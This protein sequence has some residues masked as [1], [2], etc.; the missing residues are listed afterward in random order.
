MARQGPAVHSLSRNLAQRSALGGRDR[1]HRKTGMRRKHSFGTANVTNRM[2]ARET[3]PE[4]EL[5]HGG[6]MSDKALVPVQCDVTLERLV[7]GAILARHKQADEALTALAAE[8]FFR[9]KDASLSDHQRIFSAAKTLKERGES[10]DLLS[11]Y[12]ELGC[13]NDLKGEALFQA[14]GNLGQEAH[15]T[16]EIMGAVRE[17]R[18][19][20]MSSE[21]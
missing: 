8:D 5:D 17:L 10:V 18:P 2:P 13:L 6:R 3:I 21:S 15:L 4:A 11:V 19:L 20:S 1:A 7:L 14:L 9:P 12:D 16:P